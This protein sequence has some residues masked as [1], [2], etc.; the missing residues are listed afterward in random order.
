MG[1]KEELIALRGIGV[2]LANKLIQ[3]YPTK[4]ILIEKIRYNIQEL[5]KLFPDNIIILIKAKF[6]DNADMKQIA[7]LGYINLSRFMKL[8][9]GKIQFDCPNCKTHIQISIGDKCP[10]CGYLV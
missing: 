10:K 8:P 1:Y 7:D 4:E 5:F 6:V 3:H 2:K 9:S